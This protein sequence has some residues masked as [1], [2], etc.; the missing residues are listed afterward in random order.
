MRIFK[1]IYKKTVRPI[2]T[3]ALRIALA[4]L[5]QRIAIPVC[6]LLLTRVNT[7]DLMLLHVLNNIRVKTG[8]KVIL[9]TAW[10]F[11]P[12]NTAKDPIYRGFLRE[13][14]LGL[15]FVWIPVWCHRTIKRIMPVLFRI[16]QVQDILMRPMDL[17]STFRYTDASTLLQTDVLNKY[18]KVVFNIPK[19][20]NHFFEA[21]LGELGI[22]P[23][24]WFVCVHARDNG[25]TL[26]QT[27]YDLKYPADYTLEQDEYRNVDI[28]SYLPAIDYIISKGGFVIRMGD[29]NMTSLEM[30]GKFIDYPFTSHKNLIMDLYLVAKCKFV[31]GCDS[32]FSTNFPVAFGTPL[33]VTNVASTILTARWPYS[34]TRFILKPVTELSTGRLLSLNERNDPALSNV[35]NAVT[36]REMGY[37]WCPNTPEDILE[38]TKEM[39]DLIDTG[40]FDSNMTDE[41]LYFHTCRNSALE[42]LWSPGFDVGDSNW[43]KVFDSRSRI[44]STFAEKHF[45]YEARES[46][47]KRYDQH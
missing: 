12:R 25:W 21:Q 2:T 29:P 26:K 46:V 9:I 45:F 43:S 27:P 37:E 39:L 14:T 36:F 10:P 28:N 11:W 16:L 30:S 41:Q 13:L 34:N 5:D 1:A 33:L 15:T 38:S 19:S 7:N 8:R 32:G 22:R 35:H 3:T 6:F 4:Y 44:S 31:L 18:R 42:E 23:S 17:N 40:C 24:D 47:M 20:Y